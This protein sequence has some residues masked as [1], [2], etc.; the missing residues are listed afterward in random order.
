MAM[1]EL[2]KQFRAPAIVYYFRINYT[3]QFRCKDLITVG[4]VKIDLCETH[5]P[6]YAAQSQTKFNQQ[7]HLISLL[8]SGFE[9]KS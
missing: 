5:F 2:L 8:I 4:Y 6:L 7:N 9:N 1:S 3:T